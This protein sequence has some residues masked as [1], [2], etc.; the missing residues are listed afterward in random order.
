MVSRALM[1]LKPGIVSNVVTLASLPIF[2]SSKGLRNWGLVLLLMV[3]MM[4]SLLDRIGLAV[5]IQPIKEDL[6]LTDGMFGL[7]NGI[8]FGL[9]YT[10]MGFPMGWLADRWSR[11]GT[12]IV[13]ISLWSAAT[14]G[15]GFAESFGQLLFARI[16]VGAGEAALVPAAYAMIS[17]R[18]DRSRLA[19]ALSVLQS[20]SVIGAGSAVILT[21][22]TYTWLSSGAGTE[23]PIFGD[24]KHWQQTFVVI[25]LPGFLIV[26]GLSLI[27]DTPTSSPLVGG[28]LEPAISL[29]ETL[30]ANR[31][32][33]ALLFLAVAG[34]TVSSYGLISWIPGILAREFQWTPSQIAGNY[35]VVVLIFSPAGLLFGGWLTDWFDRKYGRAIHA[36]V[37]LAASTLGL[38]AVAALILPANP[39]SFLVLAALAHFLI[40][41]PNGVVPALIQVTTPRSS[42]SRV[43]AIY[44]L[45][46]NLIGLGIAPVAIG[47]I[48][49]SAPD[50]PHMLRFAMWSCLTVGM[51]F[52][53]VLSIWLQPVAKMTLSRLIAQPS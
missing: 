10:I 13:G 22:A 18:F 53:L 5:M 15:C 8:A 24:L 31:L 43:S 35:G 41:L 49:S 47:A 9:F 29:R 37:L 48:S 33:Y 21:G 3:A 45:V 2:T 4:I 28:T 7:L 38:L 1:G 25:G 44:V 6:G 39:T 42:R 27:R 20:G 26:A 52:A 34:I 51:V 46:I 16:I 40:S 19:R 12:I 36:P 32:F 50:D 11:K 30:I 23:I 17:D 14:I